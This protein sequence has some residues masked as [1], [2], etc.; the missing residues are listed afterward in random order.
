MNSD[1][2]GTFMEHAGNRGNSYDDLKRKAPDQDIEQ[3]SI[4][5]ELSGIAGRPKSTRTPHNR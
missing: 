4:K 2:Q 5:I 3:T 1:F